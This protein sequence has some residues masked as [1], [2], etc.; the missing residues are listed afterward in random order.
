MSRGRFQP[1]DFGVDLPKDQ[2]ID[3]CVEEF[4]GAYR[5]GLT[6]DELCL[7]PQAALRFC[8]AVKANR[9]WWDVPDDIILRTIMDTRKRGEWS[10]QSE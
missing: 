9:R 4:D 8:T 5:N 3:A 1:Q 10:L 7:R 2:F 6:I